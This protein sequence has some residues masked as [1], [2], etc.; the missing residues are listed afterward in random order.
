MKGRAV[1]SS[2][3]R[4]G[5][6]GRHVHVWSEGPGEERITGNPKGKDGEEKGKLAE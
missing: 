4:K 6:W 2:R 3:K 5:V 1:K